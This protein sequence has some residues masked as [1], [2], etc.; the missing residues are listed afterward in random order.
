LSGV[1]DEPSLGWPRASEC[2]AVCTEGDLGV[3]LTAGFEMVEAF[4][5]YEG[6]T[7]TLRCANESHYL[8]NT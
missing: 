2:V 8:D 3:P 6:D 1:V 5:I 7:V 4:T